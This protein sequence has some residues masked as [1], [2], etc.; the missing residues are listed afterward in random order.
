MS[1]LRILTYLD[2]QDSGRPNTVIERSRIGFGKSSLFYLGLNG[3][4]AYWEKIRRVSAIF[5]LSKIRSFIF[6][7]IVHNMTRQNNH[8]LDVLSE[9][10]SLAVFFIKHE[11]VYSLGRYWAIIESPMFSFSHHIFN[12]KSV[13]F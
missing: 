4:D 9:L 2:Q 13:I 12:S 6:F 7:T 5:V 11:L 1:V 3:W 8:S 10:D